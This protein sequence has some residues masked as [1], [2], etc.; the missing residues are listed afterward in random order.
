MTGMYNVL[1]KLRAG[2]ALSDKEKLVHAQ[3]LVSVLG[4]LHDELDC[5][6][7][8]AYGWDDLAATLVGLPGA[9]TP[10][11]DKPEAQAEAEEQLL[12]RLVVARASID[13]Q[14]RTSEHSIDVQLRT[15]E[16]HRCTATYDRCTAT[17]V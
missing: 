9:T 10:L 6:V 4:E 5:A 8:A 2:E 13:V 17:Y 15:S 11:A 16:H 1:E 7:F 12:G 3:G 14:L